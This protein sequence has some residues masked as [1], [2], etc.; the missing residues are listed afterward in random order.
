MSQPTLFDAM[1]PAA[2]ASDPHTSHQAAASARLRAETQLG[3]LLAV[4]AAETP[5]QALTDEMAATLAG[6]PSRSCWWKRCSDLR[7]ME[8]IERVGTAAS[9]LG[10]NVMTCKITRLG[11]LRYHAM[12]HRAK[13]TR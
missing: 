4:Y 1:P 7:H 11:V 12:I 6:L 13:E 9:S 10:E 5:V 2:R 3:R 8:L